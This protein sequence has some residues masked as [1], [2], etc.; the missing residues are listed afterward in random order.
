MPDE[1]IKPEPE[2]PTTEVAT[3]V[4]TE[5]EP[6]PEAHP[7]EPGGKRFE[8]VYAERARLK[9]ENEALQ[10]RIQADQAA[11]DAAA[12]P[13]QPKTYTAAELDGIE[14]EAINRGDRQTQRAVQDYRTKQA[15]QAALGSQR[16]EQAQVGI[17][18]RVGA[19]LFKSF[20]D[21]GDPKSE[22][23]KAASTEF[24]TLEQEYRL[25]GADIRQDP[26]GVEVA[27]GRA[28]RRNPSLAKLIVEG[29]VPKSKVD[30]ADTYVE[31]GGGGARPEAVKGAN[32]K[33]TSR[34][35]D[36]CRKSNTDPK[37]YAKWRVSRAPRG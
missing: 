13:A 15:I 23:F 24:T 25:R 19:E 22:L 2:K 32:P 8:Q 26:Y 37:E 28:I 11:R 3:E 5:V 29:A 1:P 30:E 21:L 36:Y 14:D 4:T 6:E 17:K 9:A 16:A 20:P 31:D 33:L 12:A 10:A 27:V 34:E 7:L 35:L 18:Q